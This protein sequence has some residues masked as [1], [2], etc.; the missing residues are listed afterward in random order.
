MARAKYIYLIRNM[1]GLLVS[2]HTV[3]HEAHTW[4]QRNSPDPAD[5]YK[6]S[7]MNDGAAQTKLEVEIPWEFV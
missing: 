4:A 6:L 1:D 5:H 2:A 7:R 3:K